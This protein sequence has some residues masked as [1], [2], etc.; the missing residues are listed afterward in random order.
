MCGALVVG[1][2]RLTCLPAVVRGARLI[3]A[4]MADGHAL[5]LGLAFAGAAW[6]WPGGVPAWEAV[7][8]P[9]AP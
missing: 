7:I 4:L 2:D 6:L 8:M 9:A 1:A 5:V 3:E